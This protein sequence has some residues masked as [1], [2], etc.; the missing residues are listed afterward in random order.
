LK[1]NEDVISPTFTCRW[2]SIFAILQSITN[3]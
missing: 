1:N 3:I 2:I